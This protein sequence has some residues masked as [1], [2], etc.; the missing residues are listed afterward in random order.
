M[1]SAFVYKSIS[2][3]LLIVPPVVEDQYK[4]NIKWI[5]EAEDHKLV[6]THTL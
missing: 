1:Y 2:F 5:K 4:D 6:R 3:N